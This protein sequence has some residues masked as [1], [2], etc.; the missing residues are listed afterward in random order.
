[1][2]GLSDPTVRN[3]L[4]ELVESKADRPVVALRQRASGTA[5]IISGSRP[6]LNVRLTPWWRQRRLRRRGVRPS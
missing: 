3:F 2:G 1:M 6:V 5:L 4:P